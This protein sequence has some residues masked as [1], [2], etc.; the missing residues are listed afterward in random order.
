MPSYSDLRRAWL[1]GQLGLDNSLLSNT[2][3]EQLLYQGSSIGGTRAFRPGGYYSPNM[4]VA[5][6]STGSGNLNFARFVP[7]EVGKTTRFNLIGLDIVTAGGAGNVIRLGIYNDLKGLPGELLA[8]VGPIASDTSGFKSAP[9]DVTLSG[10]LYWLALVQQGGTLCTYRGF[11]AHSNPYVANLA[12][13]AG[14]NYSHY[15]QTA[16]SGAF[17]GVA[18]VNS[19]GGNTDAPRIIVRAEDET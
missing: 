9:I 7:F 3:L 19:M 4:Q 13:P 11:T 1:L 15:V 18:D 14:N 17:P 6:S 8:E 12:E 5:V 10:G 16:V 2:D